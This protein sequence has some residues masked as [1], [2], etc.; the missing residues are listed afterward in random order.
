[1]DVQFNRRVK[2]MAEKFES[3]LI[4][5]ERPRV[6]SDKKSKIQVSFQYPAAD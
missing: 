4:S 2:M 5:K 1:M 3:R 6:L